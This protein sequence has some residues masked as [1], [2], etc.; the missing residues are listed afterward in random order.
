M[1]EALSHRVEADESICPAGGWS[2]QLGVDHSRGD[3]VLVSRRAADVTLQTDEEKL[4]CRLRR[5]T[6]LRHPGLSPVIDAGLDDDG[7]YTVERVGNARPLDDE[8]CKLPRGDDLGEQ[9]IH[10]LEALAYVHRHGVAHC[11]IS[12]R[13]VLSDGRRLRLTG[14]GLKQAEGGTETMDDV[15]CWAELVRDLLQQPERSPLNRLVL[16]VAEDVRRIGT[17]GGVLTAAKVATGIRRALIESAEAAQGMAHVGD[18]N[19]SM[20]IVDRIIEFTTSVMI[21]AVSTVITVAVIVGI[22]ALGMFK[23]ID[24]GPEEITVPSVI[25]QSESEARETLAAQGLKVGSVRRVF[26]D[27]AK[28]GEVVGAIPEAGMTVREGR[29]LTLVVS[30]GAAEVR[31]PRLIGLREDEAREVLEGVGLV[32]VEAGRVQS[33]ITDDAVVAQD[34]SP[35]EKVAHGDPVAVRMSGGPDYGAVVV[36][37]ADGE[38]RRML[39]RQLRIVIPAGDPL[40][41]VEVEEGYDSL[42]KTYDRLHRPGDEIKLNVSGRPGKTIRVTI[43]GEQVFERQL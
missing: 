30:R 33:D 5:V 24:M 43:E 6:P 15:L 36:E 39:F 37:G 38:E 20:K 17:Q 3:R 10:L 41:R 13:T 7:A 35:G 23:F 16:A 4:L 22:V 18:R 2:R 26:R 1:L 31:V 8:R 29:E 32:A 9:L 21:G 14:L 12:D 25:G 28:V 40:Q 11:A 27:D 19:G 42:Q 34:P